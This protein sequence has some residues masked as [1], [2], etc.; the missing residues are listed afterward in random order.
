MI[1]TEERIINGQQVNYT[2]SDTNCI[3]RCGKLRYKNAA[4]PINIHKYYFEE[5]PQPSEDN[6][7]ETEN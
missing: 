5:N 6:I 2:Y 3:V 7:N 4:D 1:V